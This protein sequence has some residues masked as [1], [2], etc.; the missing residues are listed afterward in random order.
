VRTTLITST[1]QAADSEPEPVVV[2]DFDQS[3]VFRSDAQ[4][5]TRR[6][7]RI[8]ILQFWRKGRVV[9]STAALTSSKTASTTRPEAAQRRIC[10]APPARRSADRAWGQVIAFCDDVDRA[11]EL[12]IASSKP[13]AA[14][15]ASTGSA[16]SFPSLAVHASRYSLGFWR[17]LSA[18]ATATNRA[19]SSDECGGWVVSSFHKKLGVY[20][21]YIDING[22]FLF[23]PN[24]L[25]FVRTLIALGA[26][27]LTY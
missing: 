22:D 9:R 3:A 18:S 6:A 5:A 20:A 15:R 4:H 10:R 16:V 7:L 1:A 12:V 26:W 17:G 2:F 19:K 27:L 13:R 24:L 25:Q 21:Q 14:D 11:L 23:H 8:T